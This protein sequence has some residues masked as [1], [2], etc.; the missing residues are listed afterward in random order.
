MELEFDKDMQTIRTFRPY[1]NQEEGSRSLIIYNPEGGPNYG[2]YTS[3]PY[4]L[5]VNKGHSCYVDQSRMPPECQ[6][7]Q[8]DF[9]IFPKMKVYR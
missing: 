6:N 9:K 4:P 7:Q 3:N 8:T 1:I 2:L 5:C